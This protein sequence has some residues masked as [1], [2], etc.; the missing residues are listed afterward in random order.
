MYP[1]KFGTNVSYRCWLKFSIK[2]LMK[3]LDI[4]EIFNCWLFEIAF[5]IFAAA[6]KC[7][8]NQITQQS[9]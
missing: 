2:K 4:L 5:E 3:F 1:A 6:Y 7:H 9:N 8:N